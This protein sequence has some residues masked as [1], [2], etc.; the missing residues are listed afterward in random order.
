MSHKMLR[1]FIVKV[2]VKAY[3]VTFLY[4]VLYNLI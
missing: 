4:N 3:E 2:F 1:E